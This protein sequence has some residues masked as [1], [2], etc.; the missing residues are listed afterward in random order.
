MASVTMETML[1]V[2]VGMEEIVAVVRLT[3][4]FTARIAYAATAR[5][6]LSEAHLVSQLVTIV[7][8]QPS[9][10]VAVPVFVGT[11]S[12][13]MVITML[14]VRGTAET[15]A[16]LDKTIIFAKI[17]SVSTA[18]TQKVAFQ[19]EKPLME[20]VVSR[21]FRVTEFAT[22]IT[23]TLDAHGMAEIAAVSAG[24]STNTHTVT[25]AIVVIVNSA[26]AEPVLTVHGPMMAT[27]TMAI[28]I[29]AV[30]GT[31]ETAVAHQV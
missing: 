15:A 6:H 29:A 4:M 24:K 19:R 27:V 12:V 25:N 9:V 28:I 30:G 26:A 10:N 8:V 14:R 31:A 5:T 11:V 3:P 7:L 16:G 20:F 21:G 23:T 17:A 1:P 2:V 13:T 22:T 18:C